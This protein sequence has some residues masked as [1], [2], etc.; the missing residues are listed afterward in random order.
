MRIGRPGVREEEGEGV[1]WAVGGDGTKRGVG[2]SAEKRRETARGAMV[3][4]R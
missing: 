2:G 1:R 4:E 3:E